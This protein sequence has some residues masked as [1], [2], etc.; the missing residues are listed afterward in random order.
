MVDQFSGAGG[1]AQADGLEA[2][3]PWLDGV[4]GAED[5]LLAKLVYRGGAG[6]HGW[7]GDAEV[8]QDALDGTG[9]ARRMAGF[10]SGLGRLS[11]AVRQ[12]LAVVPVRGAGEGQDVTWRADVGSDAGDGGGSL[13]ACGACVVVGVEQSGDAVAR[14]RREGVRDVESV[15]E[16]AGGDE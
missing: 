15:G 4:S 3:L 16:A 6:Q 12:E 2:C 1:C 14:G 13:G 9:K 10:G 7:A 11:L 5:Q 8:L